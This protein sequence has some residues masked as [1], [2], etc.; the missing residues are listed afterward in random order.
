MAIADTDL[1]KTLI[2]QGLV[3]VVV[4]DDAADAPALGDALA[5]AGLRIV[6]ITL[7]TDAALEAIA[8]L[9]RDPRLVIGAGTVLDAAGVAAA[10]DAG[11]RFIVSPGLDPAVV[12]AAR[13]H[14]VPMIPGIATATEVQT[15]LQ[16]GCRTL[17]FFPAGALGGPTMLKAL[18]APFADVRFIPTGG[19]GQDDLAA[20]RALPSVLAVG[21]SFIAPADLI[22]AKDWPAITHRARAALQVTARTPDRT[23]V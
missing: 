5:S 13:V 22:A 11:A 23:P 21:G 7:R 6:E 18:A 19:I 10:V 20:Y 8:L 17:K 16:L 3:A 1:G 12:A 2:D 4:I 9:A 15:A 14:D